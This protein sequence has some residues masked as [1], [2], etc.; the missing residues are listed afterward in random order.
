MAWSGTRTKFPEFL[1]E[2]GKII[3][4]EVRAVLLSL[5]AG[6]RGL[7]VSGEQ[8]LQWSHCQALQVSCECDQLRELISSWCWQVEQPGEGL[9][10]RED[11]GQENEGHHRG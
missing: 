3:V 11:G 1:F 9:S 4:R 5:G 10:G 6:E 7:Q 2:G 8:S